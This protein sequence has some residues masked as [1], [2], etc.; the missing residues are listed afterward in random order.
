MV[1]TL[2]AILIIGQT[3]LLA[4]A[5][6]KLSKAIQTARHEGKDN[7]SNVIRQIEGLIA[8]HAEVRPAHALPKSRGWAASPD[9]LAALIRLVHD[10]NPTTVLECSSGFSTIVLAACIRNRGNGKVYSL[11]HDAIF[12]S[13]TRRL[14][15]LHELTDWAEVIDAPL[16]AKKINGWVGKWYNLDN[17]PPDFKTDL[18]VVDGPPQS[19]AELARYPA[20]PAL[21]KYLKPS[22]IIILDDANREEEISIV[23]RWINERTDLVKLDSEECEKGC[24]ILQLNITNPISDDLMPDALILK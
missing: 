12:A 23:K 17:L 19:T 6:H 16:V 5:Y 13:K 11:E 2:L 8:V 7:S 9:F 14:L 1:I 15:E 18:L 22:S 4:I 10:K 21:H 20:V 3:I 24:A